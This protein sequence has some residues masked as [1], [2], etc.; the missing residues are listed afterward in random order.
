[1]QY[2]KNLFAQQISGTEYLLRVTDSKLAGELTQRLPGIFG[3]YIAPPEPIKND[4]GEVLEYHFNIS[5]MDLNSF[6]RH[7]TTLTPELLNS[8]SS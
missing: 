5:G 2:S 3:R 4:N 6:Q 8:L 7:L 1:M